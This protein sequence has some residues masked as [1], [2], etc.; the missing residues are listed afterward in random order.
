MNTLHINTILNRT[1]VPRMDNPIKTRVNSGLAP[2]KKPTQSNDDVVD[3]LKGKDFIIQLLTDDDIDLG[4]VF[5]LLL[6]WL[7]I[8]PNDDIDD[9]LAALDINTQFLL[10]DE[11]VKV[12]KDTITN[13]LLR[14]TFQRQQMREVNVDGDDSRDSETL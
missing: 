1:L 11:N 12:L 4:I 8:L 2:T 14:E 5:Q 7:D 13:I 10:K 9:Y 6:Y 3:Q